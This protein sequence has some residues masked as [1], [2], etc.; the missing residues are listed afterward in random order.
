MA[1][2]APAKPKPP[3]DNLRTLL[4]KLAEKAVQ[5]VLADGEATPRAMSDVLKVAGTYWAL[6]R[7][8]EPPDKQPSAWEKY[9]AAMQ[10]NGEDH[11]GP[12]N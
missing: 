5:A 10:G 7:K 6:S 1:R 4:D 12:P 9:G 3:A 11:D 8:G 2:T